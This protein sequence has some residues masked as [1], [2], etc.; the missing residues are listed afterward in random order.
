[1][2]FEFISR[3]VDSNPSF[4]FANH[5]M[6][7]FKNLTQFHFGHMVVEDHHHRKL[8][9]WNLGIFC[10]NATFWSLGGPQ[11][12]TTTVG[13]TLPLKKVWDGIQFITYFFWSRPQCNSECEDF[14]KSNGFVIRLF[15]FSLF[16][17]FKC[18]FPKLLS[19]P[20]EIKFLC[21]CSSRPLISSR[22]E[23]C[24]NISVFRPPFFSLQFDFTLDF[25]VIA[26][27]RLRITIAIQKIHI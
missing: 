10:T 27:V 11:K 5:Q 20:Q 1:M 6:Q 4:Y 18:K 3:T 19:K 25:L 24:R 15:Y 21:G 23:N 8:W 12:A 26:V 14:P 17:P 2:S 9:E 7:L 16:W 13:E 22:F